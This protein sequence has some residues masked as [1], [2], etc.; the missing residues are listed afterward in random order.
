MRLAILFRVLAVFVS[1]AFFMGTSSNHLPQTIPPAHIEKY[2]KPGDFKNQDKQEKATGV[3]YRKLTRGNPDVR[4][5]ALTFDDGPHPLYTLKLLAILKRYHVKAT[6]FVV[7]KMAKRYPDLVRAEERA[8]HLVANHTYDHLNLTKL[9]P[10]QILAQW[11]E[12]N[13]LLK[14]IIG[15]DIKFCRPPGG[16][17]NASVIAAA[18]QSGL[19]TVL[20]TD[21]PGDYANPGNNTIERRV[22]GWIRNGGIILLHDG[23]QET[24]D[25]LPQIIEHLQ[26]NRFK[27]QTV[28]EMA[29][30]PKAT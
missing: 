15:K 2:K 8:G 5:V 30:D 1:M 17:Y 23:I 6:F 13:A 25:V 16:D 24:L 18:E 28:E 22:L 19:T 10:D 12:N 9:K 20:W 11:Q 3:A 21:D 27:F 4:A 7:G 26:R 14:S 29:R